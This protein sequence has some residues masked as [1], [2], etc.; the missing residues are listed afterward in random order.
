M[1]EW[2][3]VPPYTICKITHCQTTFQATSHPRPMP[4]MWQYK[5]RQTSWGLTNHLFLNF[6]SRHL[7]ASSHLK[8]I[9]VLKNYQMRPIF[10]S[11]AGLRHIQSQPS[12]MPQSVIMVTACY[13]FKAKIVFY[14]TLSYRPSCTIIA[15]QGQ[16]VMISIDKRWP[17]QPPKGHFSYREQSNGIIVTSVNHVREKDRTTTYS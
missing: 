8:Q 11:R 2:N 7:I 15:S 3:K 6:L 16:T 1:T 12:W 17:T 14:W 10:S 9:S 4:T 13:Q 5:Q